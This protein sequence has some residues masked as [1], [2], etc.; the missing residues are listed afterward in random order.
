M[1]GEMVKGKPMFPGTST[2]NQLE[3]VLLWTGPPSKKDMENLNTKF[4]KQAYDLLT[5][6]KKSS[7]REWFSSISPDCLDLISKTLEFNP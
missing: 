5:R 2:M 6:V 1:I 7:K 3:R 4:G